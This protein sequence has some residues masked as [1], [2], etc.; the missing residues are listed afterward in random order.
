M[1]CA[2][3]IASAW[4]PAFLSDTARLVDVRSDSIMSSPE[5]L[6]VL[7]LGGPQQL[8]RFTERALGPHIKRQVGRGAKGVGVIGR[9]HDPASFQRVLVD[10][11]ARWRSHR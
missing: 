3:F 4:S 11:A 1:S 7:V 5:D 9:Q 10:G 8:G 6:A 2:S